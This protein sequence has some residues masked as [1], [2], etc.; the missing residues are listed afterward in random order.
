MGHMAL[1]RDFQRDWHAAGDRPGLRV[2]ALKRWLTK[3]EKRG[4]DVQ[5][6]RRLL[7]DD[8]G[9]W[10]VEHWDQEDLVAEWIDQTLAKID[11]ASA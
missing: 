8:Q 11:R 2:E 7:E 6:Q 5:V 10:R 9:G 3:I 1:R 4:L